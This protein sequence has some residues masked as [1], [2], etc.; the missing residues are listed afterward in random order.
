MDIKDKIKIKYTDNGNDKLY[1]LEINLD[2]KTIEDIEE[3]EIVFN[4]KDNF[5]EENDYILSNE[6]NNERNLFINS[7]YEGE[8]LKQLIKNYNDLKIEKNNLF[9]S[10]LINKKI[11]KFHFYYKNIKV[12]KNE[13]FYSAQDS[14]FFYYIN[15]S[16]QREYFN[17][18][19]LYITD[20]SGNLFEEKVNIYL[21]NNQDLFQAYL[22]LFFKNIKEYHIENIFIKNNLLLFSTNYFEN[23][24][25]K[26]PNNLNI[27]NKKIILTLENEEFIYQNENF[28]EFNLDN[29]ILN[30]LANKIIDKSNEINIDIKYIVT[31]NYETSFYNE[32]IFEKQLNYNSESRL[33]KDLFNKF[34][35]KII[36]NDKENILISHSFNAKTN[37]V[38]IKIEKINLNE[39][40]FLIKSINLNNTR[41]EEIYLNENINPNNKSS[42]FIFKDSI[43]F[44]IKINESN[45]NFIR[46][47]LNTIKID[48][49][50]KNL[51]FSSENT[52]QLFS[53]LKIEDSLLRED[54]F[55]RE[56]N[57]F[58]DFQSKLKE[59]FI[60]EK[61]SKFSSIN[62][63][64]SF[65]F[66]KISFNRINDFDDLSLAFGYIDSNSNPDIVEFF[67]NCII[68]FE[69]IKTINNKKFK[70]YKTGKLRQFFIINEDIKINNKI[71]TNN[72]FQELFDFDDYQYFTNNDEN[73]KVILDIINNENNN[74]TILNELSFNNIKIE[75]LIEILPIHYKIVKNY[76]CGISNQENMITDDIDAQK[77][78]YDYILFSSRNKINITSAD[79]IKYKIFNN[80]LTDLKEKR[81]V[82]YDFYHFLFKNLIVNKKTINHYEIITKDDIIE[83]FKLKNTKSNKDKI[84]KQNLYTKLFNILENNDDNIKLIDFPIFEYENETKNIN[85]YNESKN[86]RIN[87]ENFET[88]NIVDIDCK[89][90]ILPIF[91]KEGQHTNYENNLIKSY[92]NNDFTF[93]YPKYEYFIKNNPDSFLNLFNGFSYES[94]SLQFTKNENSVNITLLRN[95]LNNIRNKDCTNIKLNDYSM[96]FNELFVLGINTIEDIILRVSVCLKDSN[97]ENYSFY[98]NINLNVFKNITIKQNTIEN[99]K[100]IVVK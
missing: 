29:N 63:R 81:K 20:K 86:Y 38:K 75:L 22:D 37:T 91:K 53:N 54:S 57:L 47:D 8:S 74:N 21:S 94:N 90:V 39:I 2:R 46:Y 34:R 65:K 67:N 71:E 84:Y 16:I 23:L 100:G 59:R 33:Y 56:F 50:Y 18:V 13:I 78:F 30:L 1:F 48:F 80:E 17:N 83:K 45:F 41:V 31:I 72:N 60:L 51:L 26:K 87:I 10:N 52:F 97:G 35:T 61:V 79:S 82:L 36:N 96:F 9:S 64:N 32:I 11:E 70:T 89:L 43:E 28:N 58:D 99:I 5:L 24:L 25:L 77:I 6:L 69:I 42:N 68:N 95:N 49:E 85:I 14:K 19:K 76:F 92:T 3:F 62:K 55:S 93:F 98:K 66:E 73:L 40:E 12:Q 15:D 88:E 27:N 44:Y 4:K 7:N